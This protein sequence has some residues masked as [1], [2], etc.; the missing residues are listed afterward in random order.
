MRKLWFSRSVCVVCSAG[1]SWL[2]SAPPY[3]VRAASARWWACPE[4]SRSTKCR[5]TSRGVAS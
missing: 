1:G 3:A 5:N 2:F 4:V